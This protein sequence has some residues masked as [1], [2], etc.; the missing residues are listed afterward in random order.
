MRKNR[1]F[2]E[3]SQ[4]IR[5]IRDKKLLPRLQCHW[6]TLAVRALAVVPLT[7]QRT[8]WG[9]RADLKGGCYL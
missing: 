9:D 6:P 7:G 4:I 1:C 5:R 3:M 8:L 2:N